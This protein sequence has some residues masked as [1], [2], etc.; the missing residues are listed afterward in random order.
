M[1][2]EEE[3]AAA[4]R[5]AEK[6]FQD[7]PPAKLYGTPIGE[8]ND[9]GERFDYRGETDRQNLDPCPNCGS[10][11]WEKWGYDYDGRKL[12]KQSLQADTDQ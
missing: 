12:E 5:R 3:A 1:N 4:A 6:R 9:C 2:P 8:C 10:Q 7:M 11:N